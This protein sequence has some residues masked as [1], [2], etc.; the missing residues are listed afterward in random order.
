MTTTS[1]ARAA[2]MTSPRNLINAGV[3]TA[4]YFIALFATGMLGIFH[5]AM[6]FAGWSLGI[7]VCA[8]AINDFLGRD[9]IA[10]RF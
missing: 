7:V 6:M 5:P 9:D 2:R 8:I 1:T 10:E 3:F 4:L